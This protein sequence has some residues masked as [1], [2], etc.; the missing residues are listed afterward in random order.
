MSFRPVP[1]NQ[2]PQP[3]QA[4]RPPKFPVPL[5]TDYFDQRLKPI[6]ILCVATL[7]LTLTTSAAYLYHSFAPR[8]LDLTDTDQCVAADSYR[9]DDPATSTAELAEP[10]A[11]GHLPR[12]TERRLAR[13]T[14]PMSRAIRTPSTTVPVLL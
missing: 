11:G 3:P 6:F 1:P 5:T 12:A 8:D 14:K 7:A 10:G 9:G 4:P 2:P 13:E